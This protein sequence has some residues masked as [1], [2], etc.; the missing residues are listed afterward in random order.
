MSDAWPLPL[1]ADE[2][3]N[4]D[5]TDRA[6]VTRVNRP[7]NTIYLR[8]VCEIVTSRSPVSV[9]FEMHGFTCANERLCNAIG[10][11]VHKIKDTT[12]NRLLWDINGSHGFNTGWKNVK[13]WVFSNF[14]ISYYFSPLKCLTCLFCTLLL[15][16]FYSTLKYYWYRILHLIFAS[17]IIVNY[18]RYAR[19]SPW[20]YMCAETNTG[21]ALSPIRTPQP[22]GSADFTAWINKVYRLWW[23]SIRL[24]LH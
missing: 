16:M 4:F 21:L 23:H 17:V 9:C 22:N 20:E 18:V 3:R 8:Y 15:Y 11:V 2:W 13:D 7:I 24:N 1:T 5:R 12:L 19:R 14:V 6:A 10:I